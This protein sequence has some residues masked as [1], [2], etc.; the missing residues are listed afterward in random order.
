MKKPSTIDAYIRDFPEDVQKRLQQ[1]RETIQKLA[2]EATEVISYGIPTFKLNGYLVYFGAF[3]KHIG[4][5][6]FPSGIKKF[7]ELSSEYSTAKGTIQFPH[8]KPL[9]MDLIKKVVKYRIEE[10][11]KK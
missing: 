5:Y 3:K 11:M 6:P 8:D 2:P 1:I 9:P 4:L 7:Q 10:N